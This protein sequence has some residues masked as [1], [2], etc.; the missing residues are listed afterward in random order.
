MKKTTALGFA[1]IFFLSCKEAEIEPEENELITTVQLEFEGNF[2]K[3]TYTWKDLDGEGGQKPVIQPIGLSPGISYS[4]KI[5]LLD[6][7]KSEIVDITDEVKEEADEHLFVYDISPSSLATYTY[8]DKDANGFP[9]GLVGTI[10]SKTVGL[11]TLNV[12]LRH[13]PPLN[14]KATKDGTAMP[15]SDD[16]NIG[17]PITFQ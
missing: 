10:Q 2:S 12:R 16:I 3:K 9:I 6:E 7:S 13:Q 15:G 8:G 4:V 5:S 1:L 11:G 14:G 17:F